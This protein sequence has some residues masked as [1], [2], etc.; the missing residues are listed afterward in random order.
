MHDPTK[1]SD[2]FLSSFAA[3][4][5]VSFLSQSKGMTYQMRAYLFITQSFFV[6]RDSKLTPV[7]FAVVVSSLTSPPSSVSSIQ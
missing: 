5:I 2:S 3:S 1:P 6:G 7:I 4:R